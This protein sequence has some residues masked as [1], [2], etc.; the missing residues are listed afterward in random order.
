MPIIL[1]SELNKCP[2]RMK[3]LVVKEGKPATSRDRGTEV[4]SAPSWLPGAAGPGPG[5]REKGKKSL[6]I[7]I[8]LASEIQTVKSCHC[9]E[10]IF[11][12]SQLS[13]SLQTGGRHKLE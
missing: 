1:K 9:R 12:N 6:G 3:G 4:Y 13:D 11:L 2:R 10:S 5:Q 7:T 8:F